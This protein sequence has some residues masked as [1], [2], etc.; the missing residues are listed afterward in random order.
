MP[1]WIPVGTP[2]ITIESY[3]QGETA[4]TIQHSDEN[5][6][7]LLDF[8]DDFLDVKMLLEEDRE[9]RE[10]ILENQ[11]E[12][13]KLRIEVKSIPDIRRQIANLEGKKKRLEK[14]KV[15]DLVRE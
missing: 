5:P 3:G 13:G 1:C 10:L 8:L 4:E 14:D 15:G 11:S 12:L 2:M 6:K 9:I 7:V